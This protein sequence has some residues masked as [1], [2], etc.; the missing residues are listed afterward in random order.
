M[1]PLK[2]VGPVLR[3]GRSSSKRTSSPGR[4]RRAGPT[5]GAFLIAT[6]LPVFARAGYRIEN[7]PYPAELRGGI[8][9]VAFTPAGTLVVAT[10]LGE[11]W[12]RRA[13]ANLPA[14]AN[15][16][17]FM[18]GLDEP[19]GL[20]AESERTIYVAHRPE[21]LRATDADGD[22]RAETFD[23]LGGQWGLES[24][25]H[26]FFFG[27]RR[28]RAGNFY[29]SPS[30]ESQGDKAA[31]S[32]LVTR[33]PRDVSDVLET[34]GH[35]SE[36]PWRGWVV[37]I[38]ADGKFEPFASGFRQPNGFALSPDDELFVTDNQGDYKPSTGLL[39]V[40]RGDFHGHAASLKWEPGFN[41]ATVTTESLWRRLKTPAVV[42]PH[43]PMGNSPGEPV[44]FFNYTCLIKKRN[45]FG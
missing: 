33:G 19:M 30:L 21:V 23:A 25:Y 18:R 2:S 35:R 32:R 26:A 45:F 11:I 15:W 29:G 41:A 40:E 44:Q 17:L 7:I 28:D 14:A 6:L 42:F 20:V 1:S 43:G 9:A 38:G 10:R 22:G 27:L 13:G 4:R 37:R 36:T 16:R 31:P 39:H 8:A 24:N 12:M 3:T 34:S 5:L